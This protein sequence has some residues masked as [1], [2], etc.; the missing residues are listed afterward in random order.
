MKLIT[1]GSDLIRIRNPADSVTAPIK[2]WINPAI[3]TS[4]F[5]WV[6]TVWIYSPLATPGWGLSVYSPLSTPGWGLSEYTDL[7][8]LLG[9][10]CLYHDLSL[11]LGEDR[12]YTDLSLLLSEDCLY[13]NLS[14]LLGEDWSR[15]RSSSVGRYSLSSMLRLASDHASVTM[16]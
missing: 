8:L 1:Y 3:L 2:Y 11:L 7:S 15:W 12:L 9:E 6:R 14:L 5:S 13:T 16:S 10:D 4:L